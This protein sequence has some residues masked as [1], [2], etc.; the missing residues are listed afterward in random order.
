MKQFIISVVFFFILVIILIAAL[1]RNYIAPV[2]KSDYL[3]SI[4]DKHALVERTNPPRLI[5]IGGSNLAFGIDSRRIEDSIGLPVINLGLHGG[6]GLGFILNEGKSVAKSSDIIIISIEYFLTTKGVKSLQKNAAEF[7]PSANAYFDHNYYVDLKSYMHTQLSA[8]LQNNISDLLGLKMNQEFELKTNYIYSRRSFNNYGDFIGHLDEPGKATLN[9]S[10]QFSYEKWEGIQLLNEFDLYARTK[11]IS[12]YF[13][14]PSYPESEFRL[15]K[16]VI[17]QYADD[18]KSEMRIPLICSPDDFVFPD[19]LFYDT[20]YHLNK[21]GREKRT[22][23]LIDLIKYHCIIKL[24][25]THS[26]EK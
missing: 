10:R 1:G 8:N 24:P 26:I 21:E 19:S 3:A 17:M 7:Y 5:L 18:L 13:L 12:V 20:V 11:N 22:N 2:E 15:N 14:F 25:S 23:L 9:D 16:K 4:I 6:L